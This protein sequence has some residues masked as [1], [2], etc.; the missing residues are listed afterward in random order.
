MFVMASGEYFSLEIKGEALIG[1]VYGEFSKMYQS[2]PLIK[3]KK[4]EKKW[5]YEIWYSGKEN[6]FAFKKLFVDP[7]KSLS[8]QYHKKKRETQFVY[9]GEINLSYCKE[10]ILNRKFEK[11]N[12][13]LKEEK[14]S[15]GTVIDIPS[16][17]IHR[18]QALSSSATIFEISTPELDD[19]IRI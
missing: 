19:V 9:E 1:G 2:F 17:N 16:S 10:P 14:C 13:N 4:V 8:L 7:N 6:P 18:I 3:S 15:S 5:G 12:L 11:K